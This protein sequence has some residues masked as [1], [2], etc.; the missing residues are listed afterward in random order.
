VGVSNHLARADAET[1]SGRVDC[2]SQGIIWTG[3]LVVLPA[4]ALSVAG[5]APGEVHSGAETALSAAGGRAVYLVAPHDGAILPAKCL[6]EAYL[7]IR[8]GQIEAPVAPYPNFSLRRPVSRA[9]PTTS[10]GF[11]HGSRTSTRY[12]PAGDLR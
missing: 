3:L 6:L 11:I 8:L 10:Y 1:M 2:S 9:P 5:I 12:R 7:P 4:M